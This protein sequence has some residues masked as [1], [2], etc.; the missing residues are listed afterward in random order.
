[1]GRAKKTVPPA[2]SAEDV[3]LA[4]QTIAAAFADTTDR[5]RAE[6]AAVQAE[7]VRLQQA[8]GTAMA[9][10][11]AWVGYGTTDETRA[12]DAHTFATRDMHNLAKRVLGDRHLRLDPDETDAARR[13]HEVVKRYLSDRNLLPA[14]LIDPNWRPNR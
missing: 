3:E 7:A 1:M 2:Q 9:R 14:A 8:V 10:E 6:L 11:T 12:L 4:K 5:L 13:K